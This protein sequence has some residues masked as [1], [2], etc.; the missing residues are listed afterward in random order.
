MRAS[1]AGLIFAAACATSA[2][3]PRLP[4]VDP[5]TTC[6]AFRTGDLRGAEAA[7][8]SHLARTGAEPVARDAVFD[9]LLAQSCVVAVREA[10]CFDTPDRLVLE[11]HYR[12]ERHQPVVVTSDD[13]GV[14]LA[15]Q[16]AGCARKRRTPTWEE[17]ELAELRWFWRWRR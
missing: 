4:I 3:A 10:P 16:D 15:W 11:V 1:A 6:A 7:I 8:A 17:Q 2:S 5:R 9:W 14:R 13:R 12:R